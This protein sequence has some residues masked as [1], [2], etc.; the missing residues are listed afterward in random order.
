MLPTLWEQFGDGS[1]L[2]Q[3]DC[4]PV[5]KARS[6]KTWMREF[7][8]DDLD[9]PAQSPDLNLIEHLWDEL[10]RR[11]RARPSLSNISV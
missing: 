1:F 4:A 2:F 11:L 10:E 6:V 8:V 7:G 5:H 9:W 3:H